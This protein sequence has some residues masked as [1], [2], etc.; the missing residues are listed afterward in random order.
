MPDEIEYDCPDC[1]QH[2]IA[3]GFDG[4][5]EPG[6]RCAICDWIRDHVA[7]EHQAAIRERLGVPLHTIPMATE[8]GIVCRLRAGELCREC[9]AVG[10][11]S[12]QADNGHNDTW[13]GDPLPHCEKLRRTFAGVA[14]GC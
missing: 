9:G 10:A 1:S 3:W 8:I 6:K 13:A 11:T 12:D 2:V 7:P 5:A 4:V 14:D